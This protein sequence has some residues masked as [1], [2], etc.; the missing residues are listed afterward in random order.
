MVTEENMHLR[1]LGARY[2]NSRASMT[3]RSPVRKAEYFEASVYLEDSGIVYIND[4]PYKI[5][6]GDVRFT[7]PDTV[8]YSEPPFSAYSILF[9]FGDDNCQYSR[10]FIQSI[11]SYFPCGEDAIQQFTKIADLFVSSDTGSKLLMN[12][13]ALELLYY[14][15]S[16]T[17]E[18]HKVTEPVRLCIE[19]IKEHYQEK[20]KL[21]DLGEITGYVPLH[22]LRIFKQQT[23]KTPYEFASNLRLMEARNLLENTSLPVSEVAYHVGFNST[24]G[25]QIAFQRRFGISP[26]KYRKES[27]VFSR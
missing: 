16:V 2:F 9:S 23:G 20:V 8:L 17:N 18:L 27:E 26:G 10:D 3:E 25:F 7:A 13:R 24:S 19:Y 21:D 12:A 1:V 22:V 15:Y 5:H 11:P 4:I 14:L 6:R